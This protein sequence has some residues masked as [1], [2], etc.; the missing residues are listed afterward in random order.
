MKKVIA[1]L[2]MVTTVFCVFAENVSTSVV[3]DA[4]VNTVKIGFAVDNAKAL[5]GTSA[6]SDFNLGAIPLTADLKFAATKY[7]DKV[8]IFYRGVVDSSTIYKLSLSIDGPF[9]L[10]GSSIHYR[11]T[12]K[13]PNEN[14]LKWDGTNSS[15]I[16]NSGIT[17]DSAAESKTAELES[18]IHGSSTS[19]VV[20]GV[21]QVEIDI[22][23]TDISL[24]KYGSYKTTMTLTLTTTS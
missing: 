4:P 21:A 8:F 19:F 13:K 14:D 9:T 24:L 1:L 5:A 2:L 23:E 22:S 16:Q 3:L 20:S 15:T 10:D 6:N 12:V 18:N 7:S 11:A 17:I